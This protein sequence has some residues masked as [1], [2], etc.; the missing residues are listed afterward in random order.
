MPDLDIPRIMDTWTRQMGFP[1]LTY[2]MNGNQLAVKQ[3]R[4][5]S[6]P[7]SNATVTPSPYKYLKYLVI[8]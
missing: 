6:D 7:N 2:T 3:T 1:V 8:V 5:L 4:F